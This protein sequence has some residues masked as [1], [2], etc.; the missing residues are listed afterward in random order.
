[1]VK[2]GEGTGKFSV[3]ADGYPLLFRAPMIGGSVPETL[4]SGYFS[5]E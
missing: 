4:F 1:V 2:L 5:L 3:K